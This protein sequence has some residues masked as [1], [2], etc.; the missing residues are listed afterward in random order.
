MNELPCILIQK[1]SNGYIVTIPQ[2]NN[3]FDAMA[4]PFVNMLEN[5]QGQDPM[6]KPN[7]GEP[8]ASPSFPVAANVHIFKDW[9]RVLAFLQNFEN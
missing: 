7:R 1:V 4:K 5:L 6:L 2:Q 3:Q 9:D 8:V